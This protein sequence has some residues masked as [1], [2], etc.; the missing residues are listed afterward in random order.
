MGSMKRIHHKE[1][2]RL[3]FE[4]WDSF[5]GIISDSGD[6]TLSSSD[7]IWFVHDP[8]KCDY[9]V[10]EIREMNLYDI[11]AYYVPNEDEQI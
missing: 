9:T 7:D 8:E 1:S 10:D 6:T 3:P 4:L 11:V 2:I 5:E